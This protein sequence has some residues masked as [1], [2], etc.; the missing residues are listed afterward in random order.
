[1]MLPVLC[2]N[3]MLLSVGCCKKYC[4]LVCVLQIVYKGMCTMYEF[5]NNINMPYTIFF[6]CKTNKTVCMLYGKFT[7]IFSLYHVQDDFYRTR[8]HI[9]VTR[10]M[11]YKK[12]DLSTLREHPWPVFTAFC[13]MGS[14]LFT[15]LVFFSWMFIFYYP[16]GIL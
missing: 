2:C 1:M 5:A 4:H 11:S 16:F 13:M 15:F 14:V 8:L 6:L 9:W 7:Y 12:Q 10:H 3:R